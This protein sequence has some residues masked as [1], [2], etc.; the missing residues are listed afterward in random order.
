MK[1]DLLSKILVFA[2]GVGIGSGV[3]YKILKTKYDALIQEEIDSVKESFSRI[4]NETAEEGTE[5]K[6]AEEELR[7]VEN[8]IN[9]N[10]YVTMSDDKKVEE[11][12]DNMNEPHII[13]P[14][15]F[16]DCDYVSV[17]LWCYTDGVVTNDDGKIISNV[18]E[19]IG[20]DFADHFGEYEEDPDTVYVRNDDQKIDY[21]I[22][23][24]YRAYSEL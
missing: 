12:E 18:E 7:R 19:L 10:G 24:E 1:R 15:E 17:T 5:D 13:S 3:T 8:V 20:S 6:S 21:Q 4:N 23:A 16:G 14:N 22:L 11:E 2:T 9:Q